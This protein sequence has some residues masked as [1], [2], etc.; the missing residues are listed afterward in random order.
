MGEFLENVNSGEGEEDHF[1]QMEA[2]LE[3]AELDEWETT[4]REC[5]DL[6][7]KQNGIETR[8]RWSEWVNS[9]LEGGA[10]KAHAFS[11][12]LVLDPVQHIHSVQDASMQRKKLQELWISPR[13]TIRLH[14]HRHIH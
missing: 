4:A 10:R 8:A 13:G 12:T 7:L 2:Q 9:A 6:A 14:G 5:V 11:N 1:Q 3:E